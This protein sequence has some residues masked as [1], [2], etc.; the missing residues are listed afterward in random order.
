[1]PLFSSS[2][3]KHLWIWAIVVFAA[4]YST[5]FIGQPLTTLFSNQDVQAAI[6]VLVMI[7]VG[8]T[9]VMHAIKSRPGKI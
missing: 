8:A 7:L 6:F 2:K 5:L 3:E 1:M 9:I 4:I